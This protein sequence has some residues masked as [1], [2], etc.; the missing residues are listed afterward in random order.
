MKKKWEKL[1][2][3]KTRPQKRHLTGRVLFETWGVG[4]PPSGRLAPLHHHYA[5]CY[6][7]AVKREHR[8]LPFHAQTFLAQVDVK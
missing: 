2:E 8:L 1:R 4:A 6:Q 7:T 5:R 3:K